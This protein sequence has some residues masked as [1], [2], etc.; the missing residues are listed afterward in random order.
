M[1][2]SGSFHILFKQG[3]ATVILFSRFFVVRMQ[4]F[5]RCEDGPLDRNFILVHAE[6][7]IS[8]LNPL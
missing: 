3:A 8:T 7:S 1:G 5:K 2:P 6:P 4:V